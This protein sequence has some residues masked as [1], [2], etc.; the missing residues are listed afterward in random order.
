MPK[1]ATGRVDDWATFIGKPWSALSGVVMHM[2]PSDPRR[3]VMMSKRPLSADTRLSNKWIEYWIQTWCNRACRASKAHCNM[4]L[5]LKPFSIISR[6]SQCNNRCSVRGI[7]QHNV[8]IWT[9]WLHWRYSA[10]QQLPTKLSI[11]ADNSWQYCEG[12][13][14][15]M[16]CYMISLADM[17]RNWRMRLFML[18]TLCGTHAVIS[19]SL[20]DC[21]IKSV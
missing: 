9:A 13:Y 7:S 17:S 18:I 6:L 21:P 8:Y 20:L 5:M 10:Q 16:S 12:S 3:K 4:F 1:Y 2:V 14:A 19:Q 11:I 15:Y